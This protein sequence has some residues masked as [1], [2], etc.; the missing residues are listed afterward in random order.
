MN[1]STVFISESD[2]LPQNET[3]QRTA[4]GTALIQQVSFF[5]I[6]VFKVH[7]KYIV[8]TIAESGLWYEFSQPNIPFIF[9]EPLFFCQNC[10]SPNTLRMCKLS[11]EKRSY[12][13]FKRFLILVIK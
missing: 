10:K 4:L 2:V 5:F 7:S 8:C 13:C 6:L 12:R 3:V 1:E 11:N 9:L